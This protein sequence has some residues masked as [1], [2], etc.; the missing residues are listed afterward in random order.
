M[1]SVAVDDLAALLAGYPPFDSLGPEPL[2]A[3]AA[4]AGVLH[5]A[6]GDLIHDGFADDTSQVFLVIAGRVDL[7][8]HADQ[9]SEPA[10]EILG[11]GGVF[12]F[13]AMLTERSVGPRAVAATEA[14]VARI[15]GSVVVPAF[16]SRR[17]ARFLAEQVSSA[18]R[19]VP[20]A[21]AYSVVD[22]LIVRRPLVVDPATSAG[23]AARRMTEQGYL[24]AAVRGEDG[25]FGLV[26]DAVLRRRILVEG[27]STDTPVRQVMEP[28][29]PTAVL[30]DSADEAMILLL[31]RDAEFLLVT[32]RAG[33]LR[34][35]VAP[36]DFAVSPTT[37]GVALHEQL[38]RAATLEQLEQRARRV[39]AMLADL[40][41][42]GLVSG[43]VVA[44]Y[45]AILDTIIR[46]AIGLVFGQHPD[47]TVD[48]FTWL[49]L[50]S[51]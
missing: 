28:S 26:T 32:D 38:R 45:S 31:D 2:K 48:A 36:R 43:K 39:P 35:V 33:E 14:T 5:F 18:S 17:G 8:N 40:Q 13:S 12:G 21:P 51:N 30:G 15:P 11:P 16:T 24:Y 34:G 46:R 6:A 7:W 42:R 3:V 10:D 49:S 20:G 19:S 27:W 9:L 1:A 50:G 22:E 29:P 25:H 37:A 41:V 47:L 23:D 44:V 4:A